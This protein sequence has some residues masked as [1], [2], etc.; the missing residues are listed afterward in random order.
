VLLAGLALG[1]LGPLFASLPA[2]RRAVGLSVRE[3]I[4]ATGSTAGGQGRIDRAL[5]S[6]RFLPP[7]AQIGLR[8]TGR[9][10]RRSLATALQVALAVATLLAMLG[11]GT[12]V[13]HSIQSSW[14]THGW[15]IWLGSGLEKPLDARAE[16]VIR[17]TP[18][19]AD[20]E[21]VLQS[22]AELEGREAHIWATGARTLLRYR[23]VDGRWYSTAEERGRER[24]AVIERNIARV[25]GTEIGDTV[26]LA[27]PDGPVS[28]RVIGIASN[29]QEDGT[30]LYI[31]LG[32]ARALLG[33]E[34]V[35]TDYWITTTSGDRALIDRTTARL[36][37]ALTAAGYDVGIEITYIAQRDEEARNRTLTT[38]ITVLGFLIVA[39][40]MVGLVNAI[41]MSV[42]ERTREIGILRC[43]G[44]RGRDV[45]R[46]F[47][48]EGLTL[49]VLGWAAAVPL[50][51]ALERLL[52][53]LIRS[54]LDV[55][56][57][58]AYPSWNL[59]LALAGTIV[60]AFLI[61]LVPLRRAV[62]LQP[63]EALRYT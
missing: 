1:L 32:T 11:L 46:I 6:I 4:E 24:V 42:L 33:A 21:P 18:G 39:I 31:P 14:R 16:R 34:D 13:T 63:G 47:A 10:K 41:T 27:T 52:V 44:A 26:S 19:V 28:L 60:L 59:P 15:Q 2:I 35:A 5:R 30:V 20:A 62:H 54:E 43:I 51:Y 49:A 40:S 9:R 37:D 53:W 17:S 25:T 38:T 57:E 12:G 61:M 58:V 8:G 3:A 55:V 45:R 22:E 23:L 50:G 29:Q 36:E 7:T 48:V 56:V